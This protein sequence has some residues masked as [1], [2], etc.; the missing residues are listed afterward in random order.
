MEF[1]VQH[2]TAYSYDSPVRDSINEAWL[3]P[4]SDSLQICRDFE[5]KIE[6]EGAK[7]LRR[8]DF[9]T[10]QVH[11]F[12]L[13]EPHDR[14]EVISRSRV[15]TFPD[16]R[17]FT[18]PS[19]PARL[20]G[21][22]REEWFYDFL[23]ASKYVSIIPMVL[24]E[25]RQITEP[26]QDVQRGVGQIMA[27]LHDNFTYS[28]GVTAVETSFVELFEKR[29]GVCQ[30]FAHVMIALCRSVGIPARYVSGYFWVEGEK[31]K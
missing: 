2:R 30:D 24:H 8:L 14:L 29:K 16:R 21:L 4:V 15:E 28:K 6:P 19:D 27:Y 1:E 11:S 25:A 20:P 5:L 26:M 3:C 12:E 10:N 22:L 7:V 13:V 18:L 17:D 9:Y 31:R 23:H